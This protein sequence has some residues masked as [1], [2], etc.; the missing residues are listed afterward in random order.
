MSRLWLEPYLREGELCSWVEWNATDLRRSS[1]HA[2]H[3]RELFWIL[4]GRGTHY[5]NGRRHELRPQMMVFVHQDDLHALAPSAGSHL[6]FINL[7]FPLNAWHY[8]RRRYWAGLAD[9]FESASEQ[10][11][12]VLDDA[13]W[14]EMPGISRELQ[15]GRRDRPALE[16]FLMNLH[17]LLEPASPSPADDSPGWLRT[18]LASLSGGDLAGRGVGAFVEDCGRSR[19]H[20][21]RSCR[22]YL[23]RSL[24]QVLNDAR[25]R[26]AALALAQTDR[27]IAAIASENG[28]AHL[29][30]FY[31]EFATRYRITPRQYRLRQ[32]RIAGR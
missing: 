11:H 31:R 22:R 25:L 23:N 21:S 10:K 26:H 17:Y 20:V 13:R 12:L 6:H 8:L 15:G 18:A 16:R 19:E 14:S 1:Q 9:P 3:F 2:H 29:G 4:D 7:A 30:H 24:T 5:L 28:F 27:K 32:Q